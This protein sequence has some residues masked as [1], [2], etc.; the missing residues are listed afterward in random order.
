MQSNLWLG[1]V[2]KENLEVSGIMPG[3]VFTVA[4]TQDEAI[5]N[6][7][8]NIKATAY[9]VEG[10]SFIRIRSVFPLLR[11]D[12]DKV[13]LLRTRELSSCL[14]DSDIL[15]ALGVPYAEKV[16]E[17]PKE[18]VTSLPKRTRSRRRAAK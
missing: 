5:E 7:R 13:S 11:I 12:S 4:K 10:K 9:W 1:H 18:G 14:L 8:T 15:E 17:L 2:M 3:V 16:K 6:I